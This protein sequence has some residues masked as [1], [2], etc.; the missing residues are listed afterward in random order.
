[1]TNTIN[2][3]TGGPLKSRLVDYGRAGVRLGQ[4]ASEGNAM[5]VLQRRARFYQRESVRRGYE[6]AGQTAQLVKITRL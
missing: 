4:E 6:V 2:V 5:L 1:V 3:N